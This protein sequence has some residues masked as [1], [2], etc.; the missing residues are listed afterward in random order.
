MKKLIFTLGIFSIFFSSKADVTL[1]EII[2]DN[3][4]LQRNEPARIWG[5]ADKNEK[6]TIEFNNQKK[7]VKAD[8]E[9][10]WELFLDPMKAGGPYEMQISGKNKISLSNILI[11][12][13]WICSGQS[14]MEWPMSRVNNSDEEIENANFSQIRILNVP[15][16]LQFKPV[17]NIPK[18]SWSEVTPE[19]I[20]NF[21]AVGYFFGKNLFE[22]LNVPIGLIGSNWGGT[23]VET[24]T[25]LESIETIDDFNDKVEKLKTVDEG[26]LNDEQKAREQKIKAMVMDESDGLVNGKALW[27]DI[28]LN[29]SGWREAKLPGLWEEDYLPSVDGIVWYRK[30]IELTKDQIKEDLTLSLGKIDDSDKTYFNG[31]LV[32]EMKDSYDLNR[33]YT[34]PSAIL[35]E[36]KNVI[37]IRVE[38]TGGG[39]GLYSK[40]QFLKLSGSNVDIPLSGTWKFK[41]SPLNLNLTSSAVSPNSLPTLLYNGMIYPIRKYTVKGA[42]WYQGESNASRAYQY[43]TIFPLMIKDWRKQFENEDLVFLFVQLAN[44]MQEDQMPRE[45]EWAELREAQTMTLDLPNTG[46]AVIIDIGEANDIH[47]RNKQDVGYRLS[48]PARKIAYGENIV[49]SGPMYKS[50]KKEDGKIRIS[51]DHIGAGL[52]VRNKFGYLMGFQIA[53][54]DKK[55]YWAKAKVDGDNVVVYSEKVKDPVAVRYA[56]ANNPSNANLYNEEGLPASPFRTDDWEGITK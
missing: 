55:F 46:M 35:K 6:I 50:M 11:G 39:G 54:S 7:S 45:S 26:E 28:N 32:G 53:G 37:T 8:K 44:F 29:E 22:N 36:G 41:L 40:P 13:V 9:G 10:R 19:T 30:T 16:N 52:E 23:V 27:A 3:M 49:F 33:V 14:N 31:T 34:V 20:R 38:D 15:N 5:W 43:R 21:S 4:V 51:F 2:S 48:L 56:W 47:P 18:T 17:D 1:P 12:E 25:S 24:W 42:I